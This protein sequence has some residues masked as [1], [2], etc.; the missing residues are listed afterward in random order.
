MGDNYYETV[1]R[2]ASKNCYMQILKECKLPMQQT[3][4]QTVSSIE[5]KKNVQSFKKTFTAKQKTKRCTLCLLKI[6]ASAMVSPGCFKCIQG[7]KHIL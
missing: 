3:A 6:A 2:I 5:S 7:H 4:L 1:K